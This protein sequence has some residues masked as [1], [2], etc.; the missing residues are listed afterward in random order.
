METT[1]FTRQKKLKMHPTTGKIMLA[2]FRDSQRHYEERGSTMNSEMLCD[3]L[4]P[5]I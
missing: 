3:R 1:S 5:A 4:K 2:V